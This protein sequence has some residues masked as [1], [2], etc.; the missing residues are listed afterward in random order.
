MV[1]FPKDFLWGGAIAANQAEGGFGLGGKG[2]SLAD[3]HLYDPKQDIQAAS[4]DSDLT[5][6][7]VE[8]RINDQDG[9]YPKRVGID[10]YHTYPADLALLKEM[11]F[12]TFRTS[13]DWSRIF[14]H[15]DELEP[16]EE[17]LAFYDRL[18]DSIIA[19]GMEPIITMLHYETPLYLTTKYGG[20]QNRKLV[21]FF[22]RYGKIL[23][24]RY[25]GKV[26]YWIV[27]NQINLV[28]F[29]SF[30]STGICKDQTDHFEQAK[31]QAIHHQFVASAKIVELAKQ[32]DPDTKVGTMVADCTAYPYSCDPDDVL[33]ALK[34]NRM[35][36][37][38]TDVQLRGSYP[39]YA[40]NYFSDQKIT[41]KKE[42][43]DDALLSRATMQF[44]ALSYYYSQTVSAKQDTMDPTTTTK[45]PHL[46]A[47]PWGWAVD[48]Q[49]FYNSLSQ[50]YDRYQVPLM[51]AENGFG[52]YDQV[53]H[54]RIH[55]EYRIDY[56]REHI[57]Q[58]QQALQDGAEIFA[59]CA[60]GPID[61]ISCSSAEMEKRYG[62]IYV[63][64]DNAGNGSKQRLKKDSFWWYQKVI[65]SN[66]CIL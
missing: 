60:W 5:L 28:Q 26:K 4:L 52:M 57:L 35:Q 30:N 54:G 17:G 22:V 66:G 48:P 20:W 42:A 8:Q 24:E 9:Y 25:Q 56:L 12:Q 64:Q 38:Y 41:I 45:N 18:I 10:F 53:E 55:D 51:V 40:L 61:I 14:P 63:D 21:D 29:E 1:G 23:L 43:E 27:I 15:G 47:N 6:A 50:Y 59:Y 39:Q 19:N 36:Y 65:E 7:Q 13:I 3:V 34:R 16:N 33:L 31:F 37:F 32:I 62:F 58:M 2:L 49:G 11:G 44:L 46:K